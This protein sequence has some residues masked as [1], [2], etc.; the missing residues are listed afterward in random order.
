MNDT[1]NK[2]IEVLLPVFY[3]GVG[4][5]IGFHFNRLNIKE[6]EKLRKEQQQ[7]V[8][9][10]QFDVFQAEPL[11]NLFKKILI[12]TQNKYY[13]GNF[14]SQNLIDQLSAEITIIRF[15]KVETSKNIEKLHSLCLDYNYHAAGLAKGITSTDL[16]SGSTHLI[17]MTD[18]KV[19]DLRKQIKVSVINITEEIKQIYPEIEKVI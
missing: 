8:W 15:L 3:T 17:S 4:G 7:N 19:E 13:K 1:F 5:A 12:T 16:V 18:Q 9:R 2:I 11:I 10:K 6:S 14:I